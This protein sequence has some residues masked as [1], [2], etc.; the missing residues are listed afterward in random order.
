MAEVTLHWR[1][2]WPGL[3]P[4]PHLGS[5][6]GLSQAQAGGCAATPTCA[7]AVAQMADLLTGVLHAAQRQ[8][9]ICNKQLLCLPVQVGQLPAAL[10][11]TR[12][13]GGTGRARAAGQA[14]CPGRACGGRAEGA[15]CTE[16]SRGQAASPRRSLQS[17]ATWLAVSRQSSSCRAHILTQRHLPAA[18]PVRS[19][20]PADH[21][22]LQDPLLGPSCP[23]AWDAERST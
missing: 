20:W 14:A 21:W 19:G 13:A 23:A 10:R 3:T 17:R 7:A 9:E 12:G 22:R 8:P 4:P 18:L 2:S 16:S 5:C 1:L 15:S 6:M 11:G